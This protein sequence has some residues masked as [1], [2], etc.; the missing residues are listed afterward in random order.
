MS[1]GGSLPDLSLTSCV[2]LCELLTL[3]GPKFH[4]LYTKM[5]ARTTVYSIS[6]LSSLKSLIFSFKHPCVSANVYCVP[7]NARCLARLWR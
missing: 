2:T 3:C 7:I 5:V 1:P 6:F 4:L